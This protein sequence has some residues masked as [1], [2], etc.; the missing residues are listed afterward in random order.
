[1]SLEWKTQLPS[2]VSEQPRSQLL[3]RYLSPYFRA[4]FPH[5]PSRNPSVHRRQTLSR[6]ATRGLVGAG[7]V[8]A[9]VSAVASAGGL[10]S[11]GVAATAMVPRGV[12]GVQKGVQALEW[13]TGVAVVAVAAADVV[14]TLVTRAPVPRNVNLHSSSASPRRVGG[15]GAHAMSL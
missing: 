7:I 15:G 14:S 8:A 3:K 6:Q 13:A 11:A 12:R 2:A 5:P 10:A 9:G 4:S 1:M